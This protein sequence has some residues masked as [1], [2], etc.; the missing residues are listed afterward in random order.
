MSMAWLQR[1]RSTVVAVFQPA[2][3]FAARS[4]GRSGSV[5]RRV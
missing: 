3:E 1:D 2:K 4:V 5:F